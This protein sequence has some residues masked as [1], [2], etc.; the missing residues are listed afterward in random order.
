MRV[1]CLCVCVRTCVCVCVCSRFNALLR[2]FGVVVFLIKKL[3]SHYSSLPSCI[4]GTCHLR[5]QPNPTVTSMGTW[6]LLGKQM[7]KLSGDGVVVELSTFLGVHSLDLIE[8]LVI[9]LSSTP[10]LNHK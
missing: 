4:L 2:Q 7:P 9:W 10:W 5:N 1:L 6:C 3:Y 8:R